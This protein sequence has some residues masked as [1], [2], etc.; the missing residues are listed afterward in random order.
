MKHWGICSSVLSFGVCLPVKTIQPGI[1][2]A[3]SKVSCEGSV[4]SSEAPVAQYSCDWW[5][6]L[7]KKE[8]QSQ[9]YTVM[10]LSHSPAAPSAIKL[11]FLSLQVCFLCLSQAGEERCYFLSPSNTN[12]WCNKPRH[13]IAPHCPN[14]QKAKRLNNY[15]CYLPLI[16][17][18]IFT[19]LAE[20]K[21]NLVYGDV[22]S[23]AVCER[24]L[25][26]LLDAAEAYEKCRPRKRF[27]DLLMRN[28]WCPSS[29]ES[30]NVAHGPLGGQVSPHWNLFESA[31]SLCRYMG[32][33]G[34]IPETFF[35][36]RHVC[37][38]AQSCPTL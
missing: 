4:P 19:G 35:F 31:G 32:A 23:T 36:P 16:S 28:N 12:T 15:F 25:S 26:I 10:L 22:E 27:L 8:R 2:F 17:A 11:H 20:F 38:I 33:W 21:E 29:N 3:N 18:W 30:Q 9:K 7:L 6:N 13:Y 24:G 37:S 14:P 1:L 34:T 5:V